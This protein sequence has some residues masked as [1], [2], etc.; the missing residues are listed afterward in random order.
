MVK[1]LMRSGGQHLVSSISRPVIVKRGRG[2]MNP[3]CKMYELWLVQS[4]NCNSGVIILWPVAFD[5]AMN[6]SSGI[7]VPGLPGQLR[8]A[9]LGLETWRGELWRIIITTKEIYRG[10]SIANQA[11]IVWSYSDIDPL[12][13]PPWERGFRTDA[14]SSQP[15]QLISA[16]P[17]S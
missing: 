14:I 2:G 13:M 8:H 6:K 12:F 17:L 1:C 7:F 11:T 9:T 4:Y 16:L 10:E 15:S 5:V 3:S